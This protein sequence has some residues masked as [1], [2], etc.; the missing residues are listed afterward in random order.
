VL[1]RSLEGESG[2]HLD[3]RGT[4][5]RPSTGMTPSHVAAFVAATDDLLAGRGAVAATAG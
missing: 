4:P 1:F 2:F 5:I 3:K